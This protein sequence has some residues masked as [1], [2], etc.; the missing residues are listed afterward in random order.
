M[1]RRASEEA[2]GGEGTGPVTM[3]WGGERELRLQSNTKSQQCI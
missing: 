3:F 2:V 1:G